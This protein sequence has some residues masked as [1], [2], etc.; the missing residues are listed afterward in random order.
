MMDNQA[1]RPD[2]QD[3]RPS[4][5]GTSGQ[6]PGVLQ[7]VHP[8]LTPESVANEKPTGNPFSAYMVRP[9]IRFETQD[10]EEKVILL[11]RRHVVT[12]L[13]WILIA[14]FLS[15]IPAFFEFFPLFGLFPARFQ[16]IFAAMWYLFTT[17]YIFEHFLSWYYNVY[18]ITDERIV[19]VDFYSILY[20]K[21]SDTKIDNIQDVT[22]V[23]GGALRTLFDYG[24]I[25]IQTAGEMREFDFEEVPHPD[26]VA[27]VLNELILEEEQER[28][29]GRV[30]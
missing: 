27:K 25:Y 16:I 10:R 28:L 15:V 7:Q 21:V 11:M 30:R 12:N 8:L 19:D 22:F 14:A 1:P 9:K 3:V 13:R 4:K 17:A 26:R 24:T 2:R 5:Q 20:K 18:I 6:E 23:T 29:E